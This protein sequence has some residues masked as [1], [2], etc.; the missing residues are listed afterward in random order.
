MKT[1]LNQISLFYSETHSGDISDKTY[2]YFNPSTTYGYIFLQ[3]SK[4]LDNINSQINGGSIR[5]KLADL[6][7]SSLKYAPQFA[8]CIPMLSR[9]TIET[10][11]KTPFGL[12]IISNRI[13]TIHSK[14]G[15]THVFSQSDPN[16]VTNEIRIRSNLP[17]KINTPDI[18]EYSL[19]YPYYTEEFIYGE[20]ISNPLENWRYLYKAFRQLNYLYSNREK[21][22]VPISKAMDDI[23]GKLKEN[24]QTGKAIRFAFDLLLNIEMPQYIIKG[25]IHGDM[26]TGN[27]LLGKNEVVY[28]LDWEQARRGYI[29]SDFFHPFLLDW[30]SNRGSQPFFHEFMARKGKGAKIAKEYAREF[31]ENLYGNGG[32]HRG[33]CIFYILLVISDSSSDK[34]HADM[35]KDLLFDLVK[36]MADNIHRK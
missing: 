20:K 30:Y 17:S 16:S 12:G 24:G 26:H 8:P 6:A 3:N 25:T 22:A 36:I 14:Q 35:L 15:Y 19:D 18:L 28:L 33:L 13:R 27:L 29:I 21:F 5:H 32:F 2:L 23:K 7:F 11:E 4:G 9:H 34:K 1:P 10:P 31:G